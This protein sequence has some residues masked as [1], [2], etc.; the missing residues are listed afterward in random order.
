MQDQILD[1][2]LKKDEITWQS[3]LYEL[4]RTEQ[5]NPWDI[6]ISILS[7][8]YLETV[9]K[10]QEINFFIS[11][12]VI[13]ASAI[14]LKIKSDKLLTENIAQFDNQ[15]FQREQLETTEAME[16]AEPE[17]IYP[18]LTI[19]TPIARRKKV[20][21]ND[22]I[23]ALEKAMKVDERRTQKRQLLTEVPPNIK[24]PERVDIKERIKEIYSKIRNFFATKK[25]VLTFDKLVESDKKE[26]KIFTFVPLLHLDNQQKIN[27][28]QEEHFGEIKIEL[29]KRVS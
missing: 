22:L 26:D 6:D 20:T 8:K 16:E 1:M 19:K 23:N 13:L 21:I 17:I 18:K 29:T 24:I 28:I 2:L 3:L 25:E 15:L 12:K 7:R 11:G 4:V 9:K 10:L 27:L 5:M 14:L